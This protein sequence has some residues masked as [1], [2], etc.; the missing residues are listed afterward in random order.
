[1]AVKGRAWRS[2]SR[3]SLSAGRKGWTIHSEAAIALS[4][5][6]DGVVIC[7]GGSIIAEDGGI[8]DFFSIEGVI[9][10]EARQWS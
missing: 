4:K 1:M 7:A 9:L 5:G 10:L 6:A 8:D 3:I 2:E